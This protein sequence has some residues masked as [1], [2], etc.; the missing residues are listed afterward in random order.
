MAVTSTEL[1]KYVGKLKQN[2]LKIWFFVIAAWPLTNHIH[3][4]LN[5]NMNDL[6]SGL[7]KPEFECEWLNVSIQIKI[8][9]MW[10]RIE[11]AC[12]CACESACEC[13]CEC[14]CGCEC[15]C[16]CTCV[17]A[18]ACECECEMH[19][20]MHVNARVMCTWMWMSMWMISTTVRWSPTQHNIA[21]VLWLGGY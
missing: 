17:C 1:T 10:I 21:A 16:E 11:R 6:L 7:W 18:C 8:K 13:A 9:W 3:L 5:V 19:L 20:N 4:K 14:E 15:G 2:T 12:Y